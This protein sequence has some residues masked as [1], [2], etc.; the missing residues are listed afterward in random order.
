MA[1]EIVRKKPYDYRVDIWSLGVLLYELVHREAPYKGRTLIEIIHSQAKTTMSFSP[2]I[3]PEVKDLIQKMLKIDPNHRISLIEILSHPW[4][5]YHLDKKEYIRSM[6]N[7]ISLEVLNL[8]PRPEIP[9]DILGNPSPR[10]GFPVASPRHVPKIHIPAADVSSLTETPDPQYQSPEVKTRRPENQPKS[11]IQFGTAQQKMQ[12]ETSDFDSVLKAGLETFYSNKGHSLSSSTLPKCITEKF[13]FEARKFSNGDVGSRKLFEK[14]IMSPDFRSKLNSI[15]GQLAINSPKSGSTTDLS[16]L[17]SRPL[18]QERNKPVNQFNQ[19]ISRINEKSLSPEQ[20]L[21]SQ[22]NENFHNLPSPSMLSPKTKTNLNLNNENYRSPRVAAQ[23]SNLSTLR[24]ENLTPRAEP[25][26]IQTP[27]SPTFKINFGS[28]IK[29]ETTKSSY[30]KY[31]IFESHNIPKTGDIRAHRINVSNINN[32]N[33]NTSIENSMIKKSRIEDKS[34][35][36]FYPGYSSSAMKKTHIKI[37]EG[38]ISSKAGLAPLVERSL[39][40]N[41]ENRM[42]D[43]TSRENR[44]Q[45]FYDKLNSHR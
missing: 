3:Q 39:Y 38:S 26:Q 34:S 23:N 12:A 41:R 37:F 30:Q 4:I 42:G 24:F 2:S 40:K 19:L 11:A 15:I 10:F 8:S 21:L 33:N 22:S 9:Q 6:K 29:A 5:K 35:S 45:V 7:S 16:P 14:D 28:K 17:E 13:A 31:F 20:S 43:A 27:A 36:E 44:P 18:N 25:M 1:P 32:P